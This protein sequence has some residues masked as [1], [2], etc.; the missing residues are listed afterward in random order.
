MQTL[1]EQ[2]F[3]GTLL[4]SLEER[5][6]CHR[7]QCKPCND[8][9]ATFAYNLQAGIEPGLSLEDLAGLA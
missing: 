7:A 2:H 5:V 6:R 4:R 1:F 8:A 9:F 3:Y